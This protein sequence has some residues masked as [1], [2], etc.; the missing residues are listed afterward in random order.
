MAPLLALATSG[1]VALVAFLVTLGVLV[2]FVESVRGRT[3][4][5]VLLV[6]VILA[7]LLAV[8]GEAGIGLIPLGFAAAF[9]ANAV[10]EWLTTR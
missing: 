2:I 9:V 3:T 10:F 1:A 4:A 7:A 8:L 6:A 5:L